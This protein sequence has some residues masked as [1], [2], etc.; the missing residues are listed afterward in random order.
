MSRVKK[1]ICKFLI[2]T[3]LLLLSAVFFSHFLPVECA[4]AAEEYIHPSEMD[5]SNSSMN[6]L[7]GYVLL[8]LLF[9]AAIPS[10]VY[11]IRRKDQK[12]TQT[13]E[14]VEI[15]GETLR[16][17]SSDKDTVERAVNTGQN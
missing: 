13:D 15:E 16:I 4:F 6:P 5:F 1:R 14:S 11:A 2:V 7:I 3:V 9:L 17:I 8:I 12:Q 10:V